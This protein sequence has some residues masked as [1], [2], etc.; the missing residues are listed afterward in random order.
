MLLLKTGAFAA[1]N[2]G[3]PDK[4][5]PFAGWLNNFKGSESLSF[6]IKVKKDIVPPT[7]LLSSQFELS[8]KNKRVEI[9]AANSSGLNA[10]VVKLIQLARK[11]PDGTAWQWPKDTL[12]KESPAFEW[13]GGHL[14]VSRHFFT[15]DEVKSYIRLLAL[16]RMNVF[17]W[18]L[19]DD[20][21]WR[22]EIKKYPKLTSLGSKRAQTRVGHAGKSAE[23]YDG[24]PHSGFYTQA[25][26]KD[27]I[28]YAAGFGIL[29]V[30]EIEMPGHG[31]AAIAAYPWLGVTGD[32]IK[33]WEN[34][35][36]T[37]Y[38][39]GPWP[40]TIHFCKEVLS[41]VMNL[42]PSKYIH[43]GGDEA[44][45]DQWKNSKRVQELMKNYGIANEEAF[46]G[47]FTAE[48][49]RFLTK[50]RRILIGWDEIL[51]GGIGPNSIVMSWRG[52]SGGIKAAQMGHKAIMS[53]GS[54]CY[55]DHYQDK[56]RTGKPLAIGGFTSVEKVY[57]FDPIPDS[58]SKKYPGLE[59]SI[60]GGQ[61]NLW[62]E[63]I[64]NE[65]HLQYMALPRMDALGTTLWYKSNKPA[66]SE[67]KKQLL[68]WQEK[69]QLLGFN[70]N[71]ID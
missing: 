64:A 11:T 27:I 31:Q 67:Y 69:L 32:S 56:D 22:I 66:F 23:Q 17:H 54:H 62:T 30:P 49:D 45:K 60:L 14:D 38:I 55:F 65:K 3:L 63:Y 46:Q 8:L 2:Q 5:D 18:H 16:H 25:Q 48:M 61:A 57:S 47:W 4:L 12:I 70:G 24:V 44:P 37:P 7:D 68:L 36:V 42:F 21:G 34:W 10:A 52:V 35:G 53:P 71:W 39:F 20:Q 15:V 51:E 26:V 50:K 40:E 6:I 19:T 28:K 58:T 13:R 43:T 29:V 33:V 41:E 59:K 1:E 9:I